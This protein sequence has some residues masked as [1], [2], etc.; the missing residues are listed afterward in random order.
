MA[1]DYDRNKDYVHRSMTLVMASER[2][3]EAIREA[4]D[5]GRTVAWAGKYLAGKEEHL[6]ALFRAC[7]ELSPSHFSAVSHKSLRSRKAAD[8]PKKRTSIET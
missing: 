7:V 1:H 2:T 4:L 3:P 6:R 5:A 8:N